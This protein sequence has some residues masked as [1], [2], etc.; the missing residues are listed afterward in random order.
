MQ[1]TVNDDK[2]VLR[3]QHNAIVDRLLEHA[4]ATGLGLNELVRED[5]D[6]EDWVQLN[7]LIGYSVSGCP[8]MTDDE[9]AAVDRMIEYGETEMEARAKAAEEKISALRD[10]LRD[11]VA[12]LFDV[13]PDDLR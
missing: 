4:T 6:R 3:F 10:G 12:D 9:R 7:Q 2:G 11:V 8:D 1:P 5:F 13:H